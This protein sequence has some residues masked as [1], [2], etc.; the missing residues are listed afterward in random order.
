MVR[1]PFREGRQS[2]SP[3]AVREYGVSEAQKRVALCVFVLLG[4][5]TVLTRY[6]PY[7]KVM[8]YYQDGKDAFDMRRAMKRDVKKQ[9]VRDK[10][11]EVDPSAV[12]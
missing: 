2:E 11:F 9:H 7:R 12:W 3:E 8:A 1:G 10:P 4:T 6:T 5:N